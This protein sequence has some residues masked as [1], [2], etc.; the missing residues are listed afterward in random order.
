V[1]VRRNLE[2]GGQGSEGETTPATPTADQGPVPAVREAPGRASRVAVLQPVLRCPDRRGAGT[3]EPSGARAT[4]LAQVPVRRRG[5][6]P[7]GSP[8]G[9]SCPSLNQRERATNPREHNDGLA[10]RLRRMGRLV[11]THGTARRNG[12]A[13]PRLTEASTT[14]RRRRAR[15]TAAPHIADSAGSPDPCSVDVAARLTLAVPPADPVEYPQ[16][17]PGDDVEDRV[18]HHAAPSVFD[19]A[20]RRRRAG[21]TTRP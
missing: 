19:A 17:Q 11:P 8:R 3:R 20:W 18:R 9:L 6:G 5:A 10:S 4:E 13:P 7:S 1:S 2:G 21:R 16:D 12:E 14:P 15:R